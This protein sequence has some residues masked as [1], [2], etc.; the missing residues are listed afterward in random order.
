M[1]TYTYNQR[2]PKKYQKTL[3]CLITMYFKTYM[4]IWCTRT[5]LIIIN[6][7]NCS[8][9]ICFYGNCAKL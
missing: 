6:V 2:K 9:A 8:A 3:L 1:Q 4:L 7:K 5:F